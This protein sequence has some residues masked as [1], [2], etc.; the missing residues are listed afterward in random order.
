MD[1]VHLL[2]GLPRASSIASVMEDVKSRSSAWMKDQGYG[3]FRWQGGYGCHSVD[4]RR[5]QGI[6]RY[7]QNQKAHHYGSAEQYLRKA[8]VTFEEE[9]RHLLD[10]FDLPYKEKYLFP[11]DPEKRLE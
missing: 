11:V 8:E 7:I 5:M 10:Q 6:K 9:F 2:H 3:Q 1:H 4:Y